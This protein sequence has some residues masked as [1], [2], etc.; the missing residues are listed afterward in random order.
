MS[1]TANSRQPVTCVV[2]WHLDVEIFSFAM[3]LTFS[4]MNYT[5]APIHMTIKLHYIILLLFP[6]V[7][8]HA[9]GGWTTTILEHTDNKII[10]E[11]AL[12]Y[13]NEERN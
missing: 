13:E 4:H 2:L 11:R 3:Q 5:K 7:H 12:A 6:S 9:Y 8:L 10:M 1:P